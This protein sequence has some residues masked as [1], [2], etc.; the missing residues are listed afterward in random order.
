MKIP[1][2]SSE[3]DPVDEIVGGLAEELAFEPDIELVVVLT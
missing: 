1:I 3:A 2:S